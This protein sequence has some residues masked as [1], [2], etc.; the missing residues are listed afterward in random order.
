[1]FNFQDDNDDIFAASLLILYG[2]ISSLILSSILM[3]SFYILSK[4]L[5]LKREG[6]CDAR[7]TSITEKNTVLQ[8]IFCKIH[9][10]FKVNFDE[11]LNEIW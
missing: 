3:I 11:L 5:Y 9:K 6:L 10:V 8:Y 2:I 1:M 4:R 7:I